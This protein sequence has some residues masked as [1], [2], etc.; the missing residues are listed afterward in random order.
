MKD[1]IKTA[2]SHG[3]TLEQLAEK[4]Q[5]DETLSQDQQW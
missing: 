2:Q 3:D 5:L 4:T 1:T